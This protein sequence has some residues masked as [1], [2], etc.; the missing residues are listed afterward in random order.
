MMGKSDEA[1]KEEKYADILSR[2][3]SLYEEAGGIPDKVLPQAE[4][5]RQII[6]QVSKD[7][8]TNP[9]EQDSK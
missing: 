9:K 5:A 2:I 7:S 4:H 8:R 1:R 3:L 6:K